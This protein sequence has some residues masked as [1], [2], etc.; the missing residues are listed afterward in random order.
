MPQITSR[1]H[2]K[3]AYFRC[4]IIKKN[5][6]NLVA[7]DTYIIIMDSGYDFWHFGSLLWHRVIQHAQ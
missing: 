7:T 5:I 3:G 1:Y 2:R 4:A 6:Q